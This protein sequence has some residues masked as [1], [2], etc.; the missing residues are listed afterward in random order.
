VLSGALATEMIAS[1][2]MKD[3]LLFYVLEKQEN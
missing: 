1:Q 3:G 2:V